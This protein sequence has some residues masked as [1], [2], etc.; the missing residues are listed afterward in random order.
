MR[1]K[2]QIAFAVILLS[3]AVTIFLGLYWYLATRVDTSTIDYI[4]SFQKGAYHFN[5]LSDDIDVD[6]ID[7]LGFEVKGEYELVI[8]YGKQVIKVNKQCLDS[9]EFHQKL[10]RIG[11]VIKHKVLEDGTILWRIE[12]WDEPITEWDYVT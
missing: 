6:S 12:S 8:H 3:L 7:D 2:Q 10:E 4:Y 1:I 5:D 11:L 9:K